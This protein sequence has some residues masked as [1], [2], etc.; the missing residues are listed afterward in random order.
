MGINSY[1][2]KK[3]KITCKDKLKL[4]PV[5]RSYINLLVSFKNNFSNRFIYF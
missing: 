4:I 5:C 1:I 3:R 2:S